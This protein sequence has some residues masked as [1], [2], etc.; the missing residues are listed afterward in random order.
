M[1]V[2]KLETFKE[3]RLVPETVDGEK[4]RYFRNIFNGP[5]TTLLLTKNYQLI[6]WGKNELFYWA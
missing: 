3:I 6:G 5:E 2:D 1:V 4:F